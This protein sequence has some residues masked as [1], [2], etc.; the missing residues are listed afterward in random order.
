MEQTE[1]GQDEATK[2]NFLSTFP[3][4]PYPKP[5]VKSLISIYQ[6]VLLIPSTL[7]ALGSFHTSDSHEGRFF[8]PLD[9][10]CT[11]VCLLPMVRGGKGWAFSLI[12]LGP[13][14]PNSTK[15]F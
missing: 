8:Q 7:G 3:T 13:S 11:V 10:C 2:K 5:L 15:V 6:V 4:Y 1:E 9:C 12:N 14:N